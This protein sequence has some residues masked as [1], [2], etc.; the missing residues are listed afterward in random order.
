MVCDAGQSHFHD[1]EV[2]HEGRTVRFTAA[3]ARACQSAGNDWHGPGSPSTWLAT[4]VF[5]HVRARFALPNEPALLL[6]AHSLGITVEDLRGKLE[7]NENYMRWHD[8][9]PDY[10]VL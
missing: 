1:A 5:T 10:R 9:D 7:W 8:G 4:A 3:E 2:T 6:A